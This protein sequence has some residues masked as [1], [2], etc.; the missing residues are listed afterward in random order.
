[1]EDQRN[2]QEGVVS[3]IEQEG[4]ALAL[5]FL[6]TALG[7]THCSRILLEYTRKSDGS[8]VT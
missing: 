1:M 6:D 5:F 8:N 7:L 4:R 2:G 3:G